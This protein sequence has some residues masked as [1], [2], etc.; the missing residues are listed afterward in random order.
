MGQPG[1]LPR[2]ANPSAGTHSLPAPNPACLAPNQR[3]GKPPQCLWQLLLL[4]TAKPLEMGGFAPALRGGGSSR[5]AWGSKPCRAASLYLQLFCL[6]IP[7]GVIFYILQSLPQAVYLTLK[8]SYIFNCWQSIIIRRK[9]AANVP[10]GS[11][12][13]SMSLP[14]LADRRG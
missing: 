11:A 1:A 4:R 14:H 5:P 13:R 7:A 2:A 9:P 8:W 12:E 6:K 3:W 10:C